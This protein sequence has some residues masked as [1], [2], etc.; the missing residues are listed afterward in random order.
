MAK[1]RYYI[2][3]DEVVIDGYFDNYKEAKEN[4]KD[5][6]KDKSSNAIK[7]I[8]ISKEDV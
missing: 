6:I 3:D 5:Y 7:N 2:I 8:F 4:F 1:I